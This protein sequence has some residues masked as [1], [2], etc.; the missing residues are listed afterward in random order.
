MHWACLA[1]RKKL[2]SVALHEVVPQA[3][4]EWPPSLV[5]RRQ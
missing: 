1:Q 3:P 5:A 4:L 2:E